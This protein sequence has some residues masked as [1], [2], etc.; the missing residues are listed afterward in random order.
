MILE[1]AAFTVRPGTGDQFESALARARHL[2]T[3]AP[4]CASVALHRGIEEPDR[5]VLLVTWESVEAHTE[6]FRGSEAFT[7][8]RELI[9]PY[10][11]ADPEVGHLAAVDL[12]AAEGLAA[13]RGAAEP[14]TAG[15]G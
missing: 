6:G 2:L 15:A 1:H 9:G 3:E 7:R 14:D 4:G 5:Y 11:A 13:R 10:F 12:A 8:W